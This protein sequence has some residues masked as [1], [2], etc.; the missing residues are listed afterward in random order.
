MGGPAGRPTKLTEARIL[1]V[2]DAIIAGS[3]IEMAFVLN[4]VSRRA[5]QY[6]L[7]TAR[8]VVERGQADGNPAEAVESPWPRLSAPLLVKFLH[9]V[10]HAKAVDE[11]HRIANITAAARG[12]AVLYERQEERVNETTGVRTVVTQKRYAA[13][14][15]RADAWLLE[16][17]DPNR[18][19][20]KIRFETPGGDTGQGGEVTMPERLEIPQPVWALKSKDPRTLPPATIETD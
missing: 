19:G 13:P 18:W 1:G 17:R 16:R 7:A 15:W 11:Q 20:R 3:T 9:A 6:W 2:A 5:G 8:A 14:D 10:E 12:G 4:G